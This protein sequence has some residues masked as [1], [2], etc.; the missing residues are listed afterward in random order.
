[1]LWDKFDFFF[2]S[3]AL[4]CSPRKGGYLC[5]NNHRGMSSLAQPMVR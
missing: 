3:E 5:G 2:E 1:M 4:L